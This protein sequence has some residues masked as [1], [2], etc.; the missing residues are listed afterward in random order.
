MALAAFMKRHDIC[1]D[2]P[3]E[4]RKRW[5]TAFTSGD[6]FEE[7]G[8]GSHLAAATRQA[9]QASY[10]RF[11]GFLAAKH[12]DL[13]TLPPEARIDRHL[14]AEYVTWRRRSCGDVSIA[15][16]LDHLRGALQL[17]CRDTDWSW[18]LTITRRIAAT[19]PPNPAKYHLVTS[20]RLCELG[21]ELMDRALADADVA[22]RT[23]VVRA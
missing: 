21:I 3:S 12:H 6:R 23:Y 10:G 1:P 4:D 2:W 5:E 17:I 14:V 19:A 16:D 20:D 13:K 8:R 9:R 18:L 11:L 7:S 15:I 22:K